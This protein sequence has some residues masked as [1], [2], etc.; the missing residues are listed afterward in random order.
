[1]ARLAEAIG[2]REDQKHWNLQRGDLS[3]V[4]V[5]CPPPAEKYGFNLTGALYDPEYAY[6]AYKE[7]G[8]EAERETKHAAQLAGYIKLQD[9]FL[10]YHSYN[11]GDK[12]GEWVVL[13]ERDL[14]LAEA[15]FFATGW[16]EKRT[17]QAIQE[18]GEYW[19]RKSSLENET[20][21]RKWLEMHKGLQ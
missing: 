4:L 13:D 15:F 20:K 10:G 17:Q 21:I 16:D 1:M 12:G 14:N 6:K 5:R 18:S 19:A 2:R 11:S 7:V 9:F 8:P 3:M